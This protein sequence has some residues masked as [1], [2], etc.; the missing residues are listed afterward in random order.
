MNDKYLQYNLEDFLNDD[1]FISYVRNNNSTDVDFWR[2]WISNHSDKI[3]LCEEAKLIINS[4]RFDKDVPS[5][6]QK[7]KMWSNIKTG[8][9]K[10]KEVVGNVD[11]NR[12]FIFKVAL[13]IAASILLLI[14]IPRLLKNK[15][16][17]VIT[18]MAQTQTVILPDKSIVNLNV[19]SRISYSTESWENERK[20]TLNGEAFFNVEKGE[21]FS[22]ET[23]NAIVEVLGTSFNVYDR[24][25]VLDVRCETGKVRVFNK[26]NGKS[27]L[28]NPG[29]AAKL[30]EDKKL[31][32]YSFD[33]ENNKI[34]KNGVLSFDGKSLKYVFKELE[35]EY[36]VNINVNDK[37]KA[38]I[39]TGQFDIGNLEK[40]LHSVCWPMHL[41]YKIEGDRINI[42]EN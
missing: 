21:K 9:S 36:S 34:W 20:L 39:Y 40:S 15:N 12:R 27:L 8:I 37:I 42:I 24:N 22:V 7:D 1:S 26:A 31:V 18:E 33:I 14:F 41:K 38:R 30:E 3:E 29:Q 2:N 10:E 25:M 6:V 5:A 11:F 16:A 32:F 17:E 4:I 19:D 35:R 23:D 13:G 28:L